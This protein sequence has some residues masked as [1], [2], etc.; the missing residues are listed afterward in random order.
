MT[1]SIG[2][3]QMNGKAMVFLNTFYCQPCE[4]VIRT[5]EYENPKLEKHLHSHWRTLCSQKRSTLISIG[6]RIRSAT[7]FGTIK[8]ITLI[9][10]G[11]SIWPAV[12][13]RTIN[14]LEK[15]G[16]CRLGRHQ[17]QFVFSKDVKHFTMLILVGLPK[18]SYHRDKGRMA[19]NTWV[20]DNR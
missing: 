18:W 13:F 1:R 11:I 5:Y 16:N 20:K 12:K 9:S 10:I 3:M 4:R 2:P 6:I 14:F 19:S 8:R 17:F 7:K 15:L